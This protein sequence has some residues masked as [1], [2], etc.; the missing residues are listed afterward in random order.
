MGKPASTNDIVKRQRAGVK[1]RR[2]GPVVGN[3]LWRYRKVKLSNVSLWKMNALGEGVEP[4]Y[5]LS[6]DY[7]VK[8]G[9]QFEIPS[10]GWLYGKLTEILTVL[11][12]EGAHHKPV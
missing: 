7:G 3:Y 6:V 4:K 8:G 10:V 12:D 5:W 2:S 9:V 1:R 11:E